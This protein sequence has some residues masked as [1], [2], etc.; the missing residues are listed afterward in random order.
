[1]ALALQSLEEEHSIRCVFI[2]CAVSYEMENVILVAAELP[3]QRLERRGLKALHHQPTFLHDRPECL[4]QLGP[5]AL[6]V[7]GRISGWTRDQAQH[8]EWRLGRKGVHALGQV[9]VSH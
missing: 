6:D 3:L 5:F 1:M 4:V 7:E 9:H 2:E 8:S